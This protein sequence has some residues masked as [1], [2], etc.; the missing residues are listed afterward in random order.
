M[1]KSDACVPESIVN[2]TIAVVKR[3]GCPFSRKVLNLQNA[4]A[5]AVVVYSLSG[6]PVAMTGDGRGITVPSFMISLDAFHQLQ[7]LAPSQ[8][9]FVLDVTKVPVSL[10]YSDWA[11]TSLRHWGEDGNGVWTLRVTDGYQQDGSTL[12]Q[13]RFVSWKL[14]VYTNDPTL[15][16]SK[17]SSYDLRFIVAAAVGFALCFVG[18]AIFYFVQHRKKR[19]REMR[20]AQHLE[21]ASTDAPVQLDSSF[22]N[23]EDTELNEDD[24]F[25]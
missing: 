14:L 3:G 4:G 12:S 2:G 19:N 9:T 5:V 23:T 17:T 20:A 6:Q 10:R 16:L 18:T 1:V 24:D 7:S 15:A 13:G 8:A 22:P 25:L 11:F 21:E